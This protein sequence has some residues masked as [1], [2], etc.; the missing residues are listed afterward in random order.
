[1]MRKW[2]LPLALTAAVAA[3]G[4]VLLAEAPARADS[5]SGSCTMKVPTSCLEYGPV[6]S[7]TQ[8]CYLW[9]QDSRLCLHDDQLRPDGCAEHRCPL[10]LPL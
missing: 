4:L 6:C 8:E 7:Y 5:C 10:R 3:S 9:L 1:M 2:L